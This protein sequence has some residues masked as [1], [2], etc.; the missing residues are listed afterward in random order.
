MEHR[1]AF[2]ILSPRKLLCVQ[3]INLY[4]SSLYACALPVRPVRALLLENSLKA[5]DILNFTGMKKCG[6]C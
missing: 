3:T 5:V 4:T 2:L 6:V 1:Q